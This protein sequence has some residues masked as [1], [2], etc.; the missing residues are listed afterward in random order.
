MKIPRIIKSGVDEQREIDKL[1]REGEKSEEEVVE[2]KIE[3]KPRQLEIEIQKLWAQVRTLREFMRANDERFQRLSE[4]IGDIRRRHI[5]LEKELNSLDMRARR[6][7]ELVEAVQPQ[8]LLEEVKKE[9]MKIMQIK[10]KV[11]ANKKI[12]DHL[13]NE[14]KDIRSSISAFKGTEAV[15]KL[16]R[17]TME[18]L[19]DI[20]KIQARIYQNS[21]K[22]ENI[23]VQV[24]KRYDKFLKLSN[25]FKALE[26]E[27]NEVMRRSNKFMVEVSNLATKDELN[28]L[29]DEIKS[30]LKS[31]RDLGDE[32]KTRKREFD[33]IVDKIG[34]AIERIEELE[35]I[36]RNKIIEIDDGI[37]RLSEM[38]QRH[39]I[40]REEFDKE[41][42]DLYGH[43]LDELRRIENKGE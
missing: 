11:D 2:E 41:L 26:R 6:S 13:V 38:E 24:Q 22:V 12:L 3:M 16:N 40:T 28:E 39:Y 30:Q 7:I 37:S 43:I 42:D 8:K 14:I 35:E 10:A 17:E 32:I 1:I 21:E 31:L 29:R 5:T 34:S 33:K 4:S 36:L 18:N 27:F 19:K 23:F 15:M 25:D 9:D 20:K